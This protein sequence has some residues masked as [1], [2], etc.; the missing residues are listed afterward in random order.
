MVGLVV[1]DMACSLEFYRRLGIEIP[2]GEEHKPF[3]MKRMESGVTM[4]WDTVFTKTYDPA[5]EEPSGGYRL[6]LECFLANE[7]AVDATYAELTGYGYHGRMPPTEPN[8]P[9]AAMIDDTVSNMILI[10]FG[11]ATGTKQPSQKHPVPL[12]ATDSRCVRRGR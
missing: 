6:Q 11:C 10:N 4:L 9:Y 7:A 5:R 1:Q 3:V 12:P 8:G 2:A